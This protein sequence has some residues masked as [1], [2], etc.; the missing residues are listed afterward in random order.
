[1]VDG[2]ILLVKRLTEP[3]AGCWGLPGGKV[4]L[5][6]S[7]ADATEREIREELG[8]KISA[9][10]LLCVADQI[11]R[12]RGTHW[13]APIYLVCEFTGDPSIVEPDKHGGMAWFPLN[14]APSSLTQATVVA[15]GVL[16]GRAASSVER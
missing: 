4:D 11:D 10:S 1:M 6:E 13:F 8:I 9:K 2:R 5:F 7:V 14:D 15:L 12:D 16:S 3:E